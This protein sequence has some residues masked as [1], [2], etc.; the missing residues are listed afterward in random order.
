[1]NETIRNETSTRRKLNYSFPRLS[2]SIVL[3][4]EGFIL[5]NL[6]KNGYGVDPFLVGLAQSMGF[7]SIAMMGLRPF[8]DLLTGFVASFMT[9]ALS[10]AV[11]SVPISIFILYGTLLG[12]G[13]FSATRLLSIIRRS[14]EPIKT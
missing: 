13:S 12:A 9:A 3:G 7:F 6:Y 4:I 2:S 10:S 11:F 5:F 8:G 1:M 14:K